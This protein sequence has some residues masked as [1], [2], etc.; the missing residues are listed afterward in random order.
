MSKQGFIV[1][2]R[3]ML[4]WEWYTDE[5]VK[6]VFLHLLLTANFEDKK[7]RGVDVKR[8][9]VITSIENLAKS[10]CLTIKQIRIVLDKLKKTNEIVVKGASSYSLITLTNYCLYQDFEEKKGRQ[11]ASK[12]A[13]KGQ[14]KGEQGANKGQQLNKEN[15]ENNPQTPKTGD[16]VFKSFEGGIG[17]LEELLDQETKD[18]AQQHC[19]GWD[20]LFIKGEYIK[21]IKRH[22]LPDNIKRAFPAFCFIV[23]GGKPPRI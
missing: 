12:E 8:G 10:T 21:H 18:E 16:R 20:M 23:T 13:N 11:T 22:G 15:N 1:L 2:H 6:S 7:W 19:K 14:T 4:D 5:K 9:Q 17:E 3:S